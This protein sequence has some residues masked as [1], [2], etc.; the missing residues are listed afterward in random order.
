MWQL[1]WISLY[2]GVL[3]LREQGR[4]GRREDTLGKVSKQQQVFV[5][6]EDSAGA[7][8]T[9]PP[10][11]LFLCLLSALNLFLLADTARALGDRRSSRSFAYGFN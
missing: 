8:V 10:F 5:T 2:P 11:H 7:L 4:G 3:T 1:C 9:M 6:G